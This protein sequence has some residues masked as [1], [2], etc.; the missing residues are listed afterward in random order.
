MA[1]YG[2]IIINGSN[3]VCVDSETMHVGMIGV[4]QN[5]PVTFGLNLLPFNKTYYY[6][7]RVFIKP[8][9][10]GWVASSGFVVSGTG[11]THLRIYSSENMNNISI[12][13][14][15]AGQFALHDTGSYGMCLYNSAGQQTFTSNSRYATTINRYETLPISDYYGENVMSVS[16]ADNY[17]FLDQKYLTAYRYRYDI[18]NYMLGIRKYSSNQVSFSPILT[19]TRTYPDMDVDL[20]TGGILANIQNIQGYYRMP[21]L[22]EI[23]RTAL[24]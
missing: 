12:A 14:F 1:S 19:G 16:S 5:V 23:D 18:K 7:P 8:S 9:S 22:L 13:V 10:D 17:F 4:Y 24:S 21:P 15:C 2:Y 6:P 20:G 11:I 3:Y